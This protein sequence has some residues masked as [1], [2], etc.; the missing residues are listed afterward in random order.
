MYLEIEFFQ[1]CCN[2]SDVENHVVQ[3]PRV[4]VP[5]RRSPETAK[6]ILR[7]LSELSV[8]LDAVC[9]PA[10]PDES[11]LRKIDLPEKV[12]GVTL[13]EEDLNAGNS[14]SFLLVGKF[15]VGKMA[16]ETL[17]TSN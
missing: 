1:S 4:Q 8:S 7:V 13:E 12:C 3:H 16:F 2:F 5:R 14:G 17:I 10:E 11:L 9:A 15:E 6:L